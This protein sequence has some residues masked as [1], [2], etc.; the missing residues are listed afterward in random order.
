[1]NSGRCLG[2]IALGWMVCILRRESVL[3]DSATV[4]GQPNN[5]NDISSRLL[6]MQCFKIATIE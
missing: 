2:G 3:T 6:M 5:G 1:M 4:Q